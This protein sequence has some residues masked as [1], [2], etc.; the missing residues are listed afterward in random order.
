MSLR[1]CVLLACPSINM[2]AWIGNQN[3]RAAPGS[4]LLSSNVS[5]VELSN[6]LGTYKEYQVTSELA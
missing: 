4:G 5:A 3:T 1:T 2:I 6:Q